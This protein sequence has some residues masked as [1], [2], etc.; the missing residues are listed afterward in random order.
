MKMFNGSENMSLLNMIYFLTIFLKE[1]NWC[2]AN[3]IFCDFNQF[4]CLNGKCISLGLV[5]NGIN[6]CDDNSDEYKCEYKGCGEMNFFCESEFKCIP[7]KLRCDGIM[8][9]SDGADEYGCFAD[10]EFSRRFKCKNGRCVNFDDLCNFYDDCGDNSDEVNCL[11]CDKTKYFRCLNGKCLNKNWVCDGNMDCERGEDEI[12]CDKMKLSICLY[13]QFDCGDRCIDRKQVCDGIYDCFNNLDEDPHICQKNKNL[14]DTKKEISNEVHCEEK[15]TDCKDICLNTYDDYD[16]I[17]FKDVVDDNVIGYVQCQSLI[18]CNFQSGI[19][20][21]I[22]L[23]K[24]TGFTCECKKDFDKD[25]GLFGYDSCAPSNISNILHSSKDGIKLSIFTQFLPEHHIPIVNTTVSFI[26]VLYRKYT[27]FWT[28]FYG[29]KIFSLVVN[30]EEDPKILINNASKIRGIAVDWIYEHIYWTDSGKNTIEISNLEGKMRKILFWAPAIQNPRDIVVTPLTGWIFW[31]ELRPQPRFV[32]AGMKGYNKEIIIDNNLIAPSSLTV[33]NDNKRLYWLDISLHTLFSSNYDGDY[34][35]EVYTSKVLLRQS[36]SITYFNNSIY[37]HQ[38]N[39]I[40]KS[41][42]SN[43]MVI[44]SLPLNIKSKLGIKSLKIFHPISQPR[45]TNNCVNITCP[46]LC[47]PQPD[48]KDPS[49][50]S[51]SVTCECPDNNPRCRSSK[52][53]VSLS[54][55]PKQYSFLY[56]YKRNDNNVAK[57]I[58]QNFETPT[59]TVKKYGPFCIALFILVMITFVHIF[60]CLIMYLRPKRVQRKL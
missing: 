48:I 4:E 52:T 41:N 17:C 14:C 24:Y 55:F 38:H 46:F 15:E 40:F 37:W 44:N 47:I 29:E 42:F 21:Q 8:D 30:R 53:I 27:I 2:H 7:L 11:D 6:N 16:Y 12:S 9:C 54:I 43:N 50:N 36:C 20:S 31:I 18:D 28:D 23:N 34:I 1:Y 39:S 25:N 35:Y 33:D 22:C 60:S 5:C 10:C 13:G 49:K 3:D 56:K 51:L 32:R 58:I 19:C 59:K 26:D 57:F 45:G